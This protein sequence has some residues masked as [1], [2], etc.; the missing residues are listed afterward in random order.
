MKNSKLSTILLVLASLLVSQSALADHKGYQHQSGYDF[1]SQQS[2]N[3]QNDDFDNPGTGT[4]DAGAELFTRVGKNGKSCASCHGNN[5]EKLN[6]K[7]LATYPI[8]DKQLNKPVTLQQRVHLEWEN[9]LGNAALKYDGEEALALELFVRNKA[10]GEKVNVQ[11][12][13]RIKTFFENGKKIYHRRTGQLNMGCYQCHD[14]YFGKKIRANI[15]SQGQSNGYPAYRLKNGEING[16]H[17]RINGCYGQLR[18]TTMKLGSDD[19]ADLELYLNWRGNGLP[20]EA[21]G[22]RY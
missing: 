21:P 11:I 14:I 3:M 20:I 9:K 2:K 8:Y 15:L 16:L 18:A 17:S 13:A 4:L 22:V 5:G 19:L 7:H 1:L 12:D 10:R 6:I